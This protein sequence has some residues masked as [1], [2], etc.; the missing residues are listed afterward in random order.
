M[1]SYSK[2]EDDD[3]SEAHEKEIYRDFKKQLNKLPY[4]YRSDGST[5]FVVDYVLYGYDEFIVDGITYPIIWN[6]I[7]DFEVDDDHKIHFYSDVQRQY[8]Q[9]YEDVVELYTIMNADKNLNLDI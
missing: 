7:R 4:K 2:Y 5:Y 3:L 9:E 1:M 8:L 6:E